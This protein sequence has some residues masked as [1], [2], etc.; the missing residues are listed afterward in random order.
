MSP[1]PL[2]T[3]TRAIRRNFLRGHVNVVTVD[4]AGFENGAKDPLGAVSQRHNGHQRDHGHHQAGFTA[5]NSTS[6]APAKSPARGAFQTAS[7]RPRR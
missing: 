4:F 2:R 3:I 7:P 5:G 6:V 1:R